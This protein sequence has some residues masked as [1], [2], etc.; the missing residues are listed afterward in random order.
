MRLNVCFFKKKIA[1]IRSTVVRPSCLTFIFHLTAPFSCPWQPNTSRAV[2]MWWSHCMIYR[3]AVWGK[4][5]CRPGS[6]GGIYHG[7]CNIVCFQWYCFSSRRDDGVWLTESFLFHLAATKP[8]FH[9]DVKTVKDPSPTC[10]SERN[11]CCHTER[12]TQ[13]CKH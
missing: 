13:L 9:W 8:A 10:F 4:A 7:L 11:H 5:V 2:Y 6:P 1:A 12:L 3:L